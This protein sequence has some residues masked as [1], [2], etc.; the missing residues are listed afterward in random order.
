[1]QVADV[2]TLISMERM[3]VTSPIQHPD[4]FF[5]QKAS[6]CVKAAGLYPPTHIL[7]SDDETGSL[8][9]HEMV[10]SAVTERYTLHCRYG[11]TSDGSQALL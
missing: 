5:A 2:F 3:L 6:S 9:R 11:P 7:F 8:K 4:V 10:K 1:M